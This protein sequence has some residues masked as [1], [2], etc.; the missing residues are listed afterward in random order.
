MS[1]RKF[2]ITD[3]KSG[4]AIPVR[5]TTKANEAEIV[6]IDD[7]QVLRVRLVSSPA[8]DPAANHELIELLAK[9]LGVNASKIEIVAGVEG[10]EKLVSIQDVSVADIQS[11]I[12]GR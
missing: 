5:V 2:E 9:F 12:E 4:A 8:G 7:D 11:K 6:G 1:E 3:A 10:R